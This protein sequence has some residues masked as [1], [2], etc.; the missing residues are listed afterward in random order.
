MRI[1]SVHIPKA[2]QDLGIEDIEMNRLDKVVLIAGKNGSGKTRLLRKVFDTMKLKPNSDQI[3]SQK[4]N[5]DQ[6]NKD[7]TV[8]KNNLDQAKSTL[9]QLNPDELTTEGR[10]SQLKRNIADIESQARYYN[11]GINQSQTVLEWNL[12]NTSESA[13]HY[14]IVYYVPKKLELTDS[15][16]YTSRQLID[17]ALMAEK[18]GMDT[19]FQSALAKIQ[20][21][22]DRWWNATHQL[23]NI[24]IDDKKQALDNYHRLKEII[25]A[26][27]GTEI[28][29]TLDGNATL[30]GFNFG[31]INLSDGQAILLQYAIA[32]YSQ[33]ESLKKL[34]LFLD[35]PEN[36]LHP[37]SIITVI[38]RMLSRVTNGQIW[39]STHSIPLLA[40]F[41]PKY[42]W[43]MEEGKVSY[44][45]DKPEKVLRSLLGDD[46]EVG[47]L[48]DFIG[49]PAQFATT[50]YAIECLFEPKAQITDSK[51][52]QTLQI[53]REIAEVI[54]VNH[55]IKMLDFGAGKGRLLLN[56]FEQFNQSKDDFVKA[57]NYVAYD[58]FKEDAETCQTAIATIYDPKERYFND[59][60]VLL[61]Y[62]DKSSFDI[63]ILCNVLH[64]IDPLEWL[65]YFG[66]EGKLTKLLKDT[67]LLL[68]V[69]DLQI[70]NGEK[71]YQKGFIV[72][73]TPQLKELFNITE[74]DKNLGYGFT[75]ARG[76]SR[77]KAHRIPK[78]CLFRIT[79][80]SRKESLNSLRKYA[81]D[82]ILKIREKDRNYKNGKLHGFYVQQF[83]NSSL[84]LRQLAGETN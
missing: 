69:E 61:S 82:E 20:N 32:V 59:L 27:L 43:F 63:I 73:D 50:R 11:D 53:K 15:N 37:S 6:A 38:D 16:N 29:R 1:T 75:D 19:I 41:D 47:K 25:S 2:H 40:H 7:L 34:I 3:T 21:V 80:E 9:S 83:A 36:H 70:P 17:T 45:G 44:A 76:D 64:E 81:Q 71:A 8:V 66:K 22:Q 10:A 14:N 46:E 18:T 52:S 51:D 28:E 74:A 26:F 56:I 62:H 55:A 23:T 57:I 49:L 30:F 35:E 24:S 54:K 5:I 42:L 48:Q 84:A 60:Q 31:A 65:D 72:Y 67:G 68:I 13:S 78:Q 33:G 12:I 58:Q 4:Q 39:I 79:P 77:L